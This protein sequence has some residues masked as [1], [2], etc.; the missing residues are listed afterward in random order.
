MSSTDE[1]TRTRGNTITVEPN[2]ITETT[3]NSIITTENNTSFSIRLTPAIDHSMTRAYMFGP[4]LRRVK[5]ATSFTVGRHTDKAINSNLNDCITFKS[6]VVSRKHAILN[7]DNMGNWYVTDVGSSSGTFVNQV[8]LSPPNE[9]SKIPIKL[10]D[11]D[12][13]QFG[14]D[15][16]GGSEDVYR[17]VRMRVEINDSWIRRASG[18][19]KNARAQLD[20][21]TVATTCVIC[22]EDVHVGESAFLAGCGHCWHYRCIRPLLVKTYPQFLCPN[23]KCVSDLEHSLDE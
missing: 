9:A 19:A 7:V 3:T 15:Y 21:L 13:V 17:A 10:N 8:R 22:L 16:R 2:E 20:A 5:I 18:F 6:K 14:V 12:L 1:D 11:G 23:C 4:M